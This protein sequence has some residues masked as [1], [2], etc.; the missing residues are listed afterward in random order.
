MFDFYFSLSLTEEYHAYG[1]IC[2]P[3]LSNLSTASMPFGN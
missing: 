2:K 1:N 3:F